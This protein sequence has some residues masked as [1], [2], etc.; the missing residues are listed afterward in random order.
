[1]NKILEQKL[2]KAIRKIIKEELNEENQKSGSEVTTFTDKNGDTWY[3][4]KIDSTHVEM[5]NDPKYLKDSPSGLSVLH[6]GQLKGTSYYKDL[7]K[8]LKESKQ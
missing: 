6:I 7:V 3:F 1:M 8:W 2:R 5:V 4:K